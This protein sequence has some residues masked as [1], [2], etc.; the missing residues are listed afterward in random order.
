M[1]RDGSG[2]YTIPSGTHGVSGTTISSTAYNSYVDDVATDL[3]AARPIV[4]GG[5]AA[6]TPGDARSK[7]LTESGSQLVADYN[8]FVFAPGS[9]YSLAGASNQPVAGHAFSGI[10]YSGDPLPVP[11]A[12][13]ANLNVVLEARDANDTFVPG[14]QWIRERKAGTWG[15]WLNMT[16]VTAAAGLAPPC[17][18]LVFVSATALA[19][20]PFG[21][22]LLKINGLNYVIPNG[23]I[24]GLANT[25]VYVNGTASQN[26]VASTDYWVF[27]FNNAGAVTADFRTAATHG[28]SA[29][30]G[31]E[32][33]EVLTGNDTRTLLGLVHTTAGAQ[34]AD[35][36]TQRM[37]IS[38]FNR[39]R[40]NM[41]N[42]FT[43]ARTTSSTT[44]VE[45]NA[46]IRCEFV[47]WGEDGPVFTANAISFPSTNAS[48]TTN[49][50]IGFNAGVE[51]SFV[52]NQQETTGQPTM[53][54]SVTIS[55][56]GLTEGYNYATMNGWVTPG[57]AAGTWS[58][59]ST[60]TGSIVG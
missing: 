21:G 32:G 33:V 35:S 42:T 1:P 58:S 16:A 49:S 53:G 54:G 48:A 18:R 13:P 44:A 2:V 57:T 9:F 34:F 5:T 50:A 25:G 31:N 10:C 41:V 40:R 47:V 39:R 3:N 38:W 23:G 24:A 56:A 17:G 29:T 46:E 37:V 4:A 19:Y 28:P 27:A 20:K 30:A 22:N 12:A 11:P 6:T 26:L 59:A 36:A 45:L 8:T 60:V 15:S 43:A 14:T 55:K 51:R 7:L 52:E